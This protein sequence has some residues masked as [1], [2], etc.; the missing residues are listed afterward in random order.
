MNHA[1]QHIAIYDVFSTWLDICVLL[2]VAV[3]N[4]FSLELCSP[5]QLCTM[6]TYKRPSRI[7]TDLYNLNPCYYRA[8]YEHRWLSKAARTC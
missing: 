1:C 4:A 2:N 5:S 8:D 7:K 6:S 3:A